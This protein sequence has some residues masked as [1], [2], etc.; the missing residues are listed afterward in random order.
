MTTT[1]TLFG[2]DLEPG[3]EVMVGYMYKYSSY[4][5]LWANTVVLIRGD[6]VLHFEESAYVEKGTEKW[7]PVPPPVD[8]TDRE[9]RTGLWSEDSGASFGVWLYQ[10]PD[11][12]YERIRFDGAVRRTEE[13]DGSWLVRKPVFRRDK[14]RITDALDAVRE[15]LG[16]KGNYDF[17][18][19]NSDQVMDCLKRGAEWFRAPIGVKV[20]GVTRE[21]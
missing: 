16:Q 13:F 12:T 18:Y 9:I 7:D 2:H 5:E 8:E 17:P 21:I 15:Y 14:I 19:G 10:G 4:P 6:K 11:I 20:D 1:L 3:D